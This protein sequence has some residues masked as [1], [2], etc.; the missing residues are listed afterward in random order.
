MVGNGSVFERGNR[1]PVKILAYF[2]PPASA[3]LSELRA[4]DQRSANE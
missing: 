1:V 3:F 2:K 4:K